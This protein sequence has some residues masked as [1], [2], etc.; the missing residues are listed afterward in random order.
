MTTRRAGPTAAEP[1]KVAMALKGEGKKAVVSAPRD[2]RGRCGDGRLQELDQ[3]GRR[4]AVRARRGRSQP[5][6]EVIKAGNAWGEK[7]KPL[8][9]WIELKGG[10]PNA[11]AGTSETATQ[12]LAAG[13]V[14]GAAARRQPVRRVRGDRRGQG[15]VATPAATI[16]AT[17]YSFRST[18]PEGGQVQGAVRQ[19]GRRAALRRRPADQP[20]QVDRGRQDLLQGGKGPPRSARRAA[21]TARSATAAANRYS[22]WTSKRA[23]T[24]SCASSPTARADRPTWP[25]A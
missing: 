15:Q 13:Q 19:Q 2:G 1:K 23:N 8:P 5:P 20:G 24:P 12:S 6:Q 22:P 4:A 25:R 11:P 3:E 10:V 16:D 21:S 17:E 14:P 18:G 7:G 9:K